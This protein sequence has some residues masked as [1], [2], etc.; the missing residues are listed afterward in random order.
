MTAS[1]LVLVA[2]LAAPARAAPP[3]ADPEEM[4]EVDVQ[5]LEVNR[6]KLTRAGLDWERL[7]ESPSISSLAVRETPLHVV[8]QPPVPA[9]P[10]TGT[11]RRGR[12]DAFIHLL[13]E[14]EY[15]KLLAK[16]KLL[17]MN[18]K[19]ANFLVGGELPVVAQT[20]VGHTSITWKEYGVRLRIRPE[21]RNGAIRTHVRAELSTVDPTNSVQLL[22]GSYLPALRSRWAET[23]V[24]LANRATV[25]IAGLIQ[26][27]ESTATVGLPLLSE[28]PLLGW[29][30]RQTRLERNETELVIFVTPGL[31]SGQA[32][33]EGA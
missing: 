27:E 15:G 13:Q 28:L 1:A 16:P 14:G 20:S 5:V 18:G 11:F 30:F 2:L 31:V 21:H 29:V 33:A 32:G 23:D 9:A 6:T 26:T 8:E 19:D 3:V 4:I 7:L 24:E 25:I 10:R 17:T 12:V 22:N